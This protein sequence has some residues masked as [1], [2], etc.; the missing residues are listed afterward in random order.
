MSIFG[1]LT[2]EST[3]SRLILLLHVGHSVTKGAQ[4]SYSQDEIKHGAFGFVSLSCLSMEWEGNSEPVHNKKMGR[5]E[6]NREKKSEKHR[7]TME[8]KR[9]MVARKGKLIVSDRRAVS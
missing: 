5:R 9:L 2:F 6:R 8:A 7:V 3:D 4:V 1:T